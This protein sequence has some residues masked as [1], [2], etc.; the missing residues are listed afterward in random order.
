[1]HARR[2]T[3]FASFEAVPFIEEASGEVEIDE[4]DL[5]IDTYRSSGAG[6]QHVNVTDSAVRITHLPTGLVATCQNERSQG[7]NRDT[8]MK[9]LRSKLYQLEVEKRKEA[10]TLLEGEKREIGFG[11]QIRSYVLQPYQLIKDLR[12]GYEVG[13]PQRVLDGDLDGFIEAYLADRARKTAD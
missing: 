6:G 13:D 5:R 7:R 10:Q 1:M 11:S 4:K 8:A 3:S 2:Q 9:L 12:T